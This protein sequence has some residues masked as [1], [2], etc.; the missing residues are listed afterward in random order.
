MGTWNN[1]PMKY[2]PPGKRNNNSKVWSLKKVGGNFNLDFYFLVL[3]HVYVKIVISV[4]FWISKIWEFEKKKSW[5]FKNKNNLGWKKKSSRLGGKIQM[6]SINNGAITW[7]WV[8][9]G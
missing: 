7:V 4:S 6:L 2:T 8:C 9:M 5:F 3:T 1:S